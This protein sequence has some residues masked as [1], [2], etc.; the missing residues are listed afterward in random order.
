MKKALI[1]GISRQ[2]CSYLANFSLSKNYKVHGLKS[3]SATTNNKN[4][5]RFKGEIEFVSSGL[6][7][8]SS[9]IEAVKIA[10][11]DEVYHLIAQSFEEN[12]WL[13]YLYRVNNSS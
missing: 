3:S 2:D 13:Q 10:E 9:L 11:P 12:S 7:D 1:T 4:I 5:K 8:I 6:L